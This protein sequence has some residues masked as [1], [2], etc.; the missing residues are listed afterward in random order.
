MASALTCPY[1]Y[2]EVNARQI[3]FRCSGRPGP[4]GACHT[5]IDRVLAAQMGD[6]EAQYPSFE[7][8]GRRVRTVHKDCGSETYERLCP[9][10]HS[11][12]PVHFG[13]SDGRLIALVGAKGSGKTVYMT[14]LLHELMY[15]V[16]RRFNASL[17]GGDE[18]TRAK[19]EENYETPL[20]DRGELYDTTQSAKTMA[21]GSARPLVFSVTVGANGTNRFPSRNRVNRTVLSFFDTAGEDLTDQR[22]VDQNVRYLTSADGIILLLDPLQMRGA[23]PLV[24]AETVLPEPAGVKDSPANVLTRITQLLHVGTGTKPGRRINTPIAVAFSKMDALWEAFP[25]GSPLRSAPPAVPRFHEP[26]SLAVHA[27]VQALLHDWAGHN[28]DE[29]L[30]ANYS[31]YRLFG[32]SALGQSPEKGINVSRVSTLGVQP[33]RVEDPFLW[34]LSEFRTINRITKAGRGE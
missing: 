17:L 32:L 10:C 18:W 25:E 8:D 15:G 20:Y 21:A 23:R 6:H 33:W 28:L 12:L 24:D 2:R 9:H 34:L 26:D 7:A 19:F 3:R 30:R 29:A 16:G 5:A 31:R 22:S 11:A 27:Q 13:R 14:V 1:C 4:Q